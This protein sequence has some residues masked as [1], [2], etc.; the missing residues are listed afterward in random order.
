MK[1]LLINITKWIKAIVKFKPIKAPVMGISISLII[2][3]ILML[4]GNPPTPRIPQTVPDIQIIGTDTGRTIENYITSKNEWNSDVALTNIYRPQ[5]DDKWSL[6]KQDKEDEEKEQKQKPEQLEISWEVEDPARS[7]EEQVVQ[8]YFW[9]DIQGDLEGKRK[10]L[11][12]T[13]TSQ[14]EL[15]NEEKRLKEDIRKIES[16]TIHEIK[17]LEKQEYTTEQL[18]NGDWNPYYYDRYEKIVADYDL[19]TYSIISVT[20]T[21]K[22]SKAYVKLSPQWADGL[23]TRNFIVGKGPKDT[24]YKIYDFGMV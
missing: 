13:Q 2:V 15:E 22:Y 16:Y 24:D 21:D 18:E 7:P 12:N 9:Y 23:H 17:T 14:I 8:D 6:I 11:P 1:G 5:V 3:L 20:Y 4:G 10:L 19:E